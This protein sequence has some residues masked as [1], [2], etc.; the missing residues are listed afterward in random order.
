[1]TNNLTRSRVLQ[2]YK[3]LIKLS[4]TWQAVDHPAKTAEER[5]Y[6]RN[7]TRNLFRKNKHV[8]SDC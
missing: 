4:H 6:I 7:E 3:R 1:M 8:K 2:L 5:L